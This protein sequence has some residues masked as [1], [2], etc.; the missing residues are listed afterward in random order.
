MNKDKAWDIVIFIL[1]MIAVA[2]VLT[3]IFVLSMHEARMNTPCEELLKEQAGS[4]YKPI[5]KRCMKG[6]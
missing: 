4:G 3:A 1:S 6:E 5:P 2:L